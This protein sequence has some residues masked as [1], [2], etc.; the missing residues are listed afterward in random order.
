MWRC[1]KCGGLRLGS[2][3][4]PR[5]HYN[6]APPSPSSSAERTPTKRSPVSQNALAL[7]GAV[8][9][10]LKR[11]GWKL[12]LDFDYYYYF[13][14]CRTDSHGPYLAHHGPHG[15]Y[16]GRQLTLEIQWREILVE[17]VWRQLQRQPALM[18]TLGW[19]E[20]LRQPA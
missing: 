12:A 11:E 10:S 14:L 6:K 2:T 4:T 15:P 19:R 17:L 7:S 20:R 16:R 13:L 8:C 3:H 18:T 1:W 9:W 5:D